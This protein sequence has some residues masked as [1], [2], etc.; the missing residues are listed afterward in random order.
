M[1][2]KFSCY[3]STEV[4]I[5]CI[6]GFYSDKNISI[7]IIPFLLYSNFVHSNLSKVIL[8]PSDML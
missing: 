3:L 5:R 1:M 8:A 4:H 6:T 2:L 7:L